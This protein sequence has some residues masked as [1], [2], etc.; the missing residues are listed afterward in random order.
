[1]RMKAQART[2]GARG[3]SAHSE[4]SCIYQSATGPP[5]V[6]ARGRHRVLEQFQEKWEPVFRPELRK[7]K[8]IEHFHDSEKNG[9]AVGPID[10][11]RP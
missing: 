9:D 1:M 11:P 7:N 6:L 3:I 2:S 10:R 8:E 5:R 4:L